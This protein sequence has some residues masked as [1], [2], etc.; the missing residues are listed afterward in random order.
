MR[1]SSRNSGLIAILFNRYRWIGVAF[2]MFAAHSTSVLADNDRFKMLMS[3]NTNHSAVTNIPLVFVD[4]VMSASNGTMSIEAKGPEVVSPFEQFRPVSTGAFD[5]LFT[6]G[7]YHTGTT[8]IGASLDAVPPDVQWRRDS[9]VWQWLDDYYQSEHNLKVIA[10]TVAATGFRIFLH[11]SID[12]TADLQGAAIR[13][14]HTQRGL[15]A[16]LSATPVLLP[17]AEIYSA[18]E[19]GV[20]DGLTWGSVGAY[21]FKFHEV[22]P[23][24]VEPSFGSVSYLILMNLDVFKALSL[25]QQTILVDAG[26]RLEDQTVQRFEGLYKKERGLMLAE[27]ARMVTIDAYDQHTANEQFAET[28]WEMAIEYSGDSAREFRDLVYSNSP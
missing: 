13:S 14:L 3:W 12:A 9:G 21:G 28:V 22:A 19:K 10:V 26:R 18:L 7:L 4:E 5:L 17:P 20:I 25:Q 27:G 23:Q 8:W 6:H 24:I 16:S 15:M 1:T 2:T 11:D